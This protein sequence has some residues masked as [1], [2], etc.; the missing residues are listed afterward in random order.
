MPIYNIILAIVVVSAF[1]NNYQ[2]N[3][4][5]ENYRKELNFAETEIVQLQTEITILQCNK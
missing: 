1:V 3:K 5:I 2:K 4:I